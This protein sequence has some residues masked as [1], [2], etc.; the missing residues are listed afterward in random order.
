M[1]IYEYQCREC[2]AEF[3]LSQSITEPALKAYP[4]DR[5]EGTDEGFEPP[6]GAKAC[7]CDG[8]IKRL[9]GPTSFKLTGGGWTPKFH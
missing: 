8:A 4:H 5:A 2:G 9:L 1:P 6:P 7:T 3:E